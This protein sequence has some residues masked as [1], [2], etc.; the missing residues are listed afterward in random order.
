M[1]KNPATPL[2]L[3]FIFLSL[4]LLSGCGSSSGS[5]GSAVSGDSGTSGPTATFTA[6]AGFIEIAPVSFY[7][8]K[9]GKKLDFTSS[10]A[11]MFYDFHPADEGAE[12]KPLFVFYNGG[13]G[14]S[15]TAGLLSHNT[16]PMTL[17]SAV[18]GDAKIAA[19]PTSWTG[20][21][22]TLHIDARM[23]GFSY[24]LISD[25][26]SEEKRNSE[27][28]AQN[29][30]C[31]LDGADFIR[32]ILRFLDAHPGIRK[33]P[34]VLVG[35][36]Y[37]GVRTSVVLHI[38]LN[39]RDYGNGREIYQDQALVDEIQAHYNAVFPAYSGQD[40]TPSTIVQQFGRQVL[41]EPLITSHQLDVSGEYFQQQGSLMYQLA[42]ETGTVFVPYSP[43]QGPGDP[44][45]N[46][47]TF[48]DQTAMRDIYIY[49][50]ERDWLNDKELSAKAR[51]MYTDVLSELAGCDARGIA[52][53]YASERSQA[54]RVGSVQDQQRSAGAGGLS[55]A[56][57]LPLKTRLRSQI[58]SRID[59]RRAT[60]VV[61]DMDTVFGSLAAWDR[62]FIICNNQ[63]NNA[64]YQ[65]TA[66]AAGFDIDPMQL[67]YGR[68][69][70]KNAAVVK[71]FITDAA[72]DVIIYSDATPKGL[73]RYTD[74]LTSSVYDT[75]IESG[76]AR[77]GWIILTYRPG[78]YSEFPGLTTRTVRFPP[79]SKS[80]HSVPMTQP[81]DILSDVTRWLLYDE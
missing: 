33:N 58:L 74:I 48:V 26:S 16:A 60:R 69:F 1:K 25:P 29:F 39:Y 6:E 41:I 14:C 45:S 68:M 23:T 44:Y 22:N 15:T 8:Q 9:E 70:L 53:L 64:F 19:C 51:F 35:E 31:Y 71:T 47:I 20:L 40:L 73:G 3:I 52:G 13:P 12:G 61:G 81:A 10:T 79:Y 55:G 18:T 76:V 62:Y 54:F 5:G 42:T 72:L 80:C 2:F 7:F 57:Y 27:F 34:I 56:D 63:I 37:G 28:D 21:G 50:K 77:P 75:A 38:L 46:G 36:S 65:N 17:D 11:R 78:I 49:T 24:D 32:V 30:N 4:S 43:A 67:R 59:F 66:T